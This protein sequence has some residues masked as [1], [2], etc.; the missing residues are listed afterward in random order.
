MKKT[1]RWRIYWLVHFAVSFFSRFY[2]LFMFIIYLL[3]YA[4][5]PSIDNMGRVCEE[6]TPIVGRVEVAEETNMK[7]VFESTS[8][9]PL[10]RRK[11]NKNDDPAD[12]EGFLGP[13]GSYIDEKKVVKPEPVSIT[14][15]FS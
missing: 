1:G 2:I 12:I 9:R 13:W 14:H 15:F 11:R 7:T 8:K 3:G 6:V 10:D 4:L 5:D